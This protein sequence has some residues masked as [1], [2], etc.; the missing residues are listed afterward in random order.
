M[1]RRKKFLWMRE[2][3]EHL[4]ACCE[5]WQEEDAEQNTEYLAAAIQRDLDE[6]RR[7]AQSLAREARTR[8]L[9]TAAAA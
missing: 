9:T 1:D 4:A 6:A 7:V 3:L 5:Q 2:I 8:L